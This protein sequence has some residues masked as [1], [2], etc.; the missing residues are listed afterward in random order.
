MKKGQLPEHRGG[1]SA[2]PQRVI[3]RRKKLEVQRE[4]SLGIEKAPIG[5]TGIGGGTDFC[6]THMCSN[7]T[8]PW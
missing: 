2:E 4:L 3:L 5:N 7:N 1:I 6:N 8:T